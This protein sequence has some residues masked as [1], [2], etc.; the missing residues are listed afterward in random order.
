LPLITVTEAIR[1]DEP[2]W[3]LRE[4]NMPRQGV[5]YRFQEV[6]VIRDGNVAVWFTQLGPASA[7]KANTVNFILGNVFPGGR[8]EAYHT[9]GQAREW[10]DIEREKGTPDVALD[11]EI[12]W[13]Q[14]WADEQDRLRMEARKQSIFGPDFRKMRY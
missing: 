4:F 12:D 8:F 10:A 14:A 13:A 9:V 11:D 2:C 7:F 5:Y 1:E 3:S 6:R